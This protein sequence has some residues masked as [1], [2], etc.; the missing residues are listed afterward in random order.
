MQVISWHDHQ[1]F[2]D[3]VQTF[4]IENMQINFKYTTLSYSW[5]LYFLH[6]DNKNSQN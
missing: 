5:K 4:L 6:R 2:P 1:K 3:Q